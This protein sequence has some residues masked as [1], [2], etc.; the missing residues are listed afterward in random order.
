M[1]NTA[2]TPDEVDSNVDAKKQRLAKLKMEKERL[3]AE[4]ASAEEFAIAPPTKTAAG[5]PAASKKPPTSASKPPAPKPKK[6]QHAGSNA[7]EIR[8]EN[9]GSS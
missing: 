6:R 3:E 1:S 9:A 5:K 8:N 7:R 2:P 4:L